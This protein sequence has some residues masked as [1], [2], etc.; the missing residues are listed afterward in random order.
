MGRYMTE[1]RCE[2]AS[3]EAIHVGDRVAIA[4]GK[5][6]DRCGTVVFVLGRNEFSP[7]FSEE[8]WRYLGKG[9]IVKFDD[10][11]LVHYTKSESDMELI[12]R[13]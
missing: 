8:Q 11:T 13:A 7:G 4:P 6:A 3:G 10:G 5:S 1:V 2:Y 12:E 9:F